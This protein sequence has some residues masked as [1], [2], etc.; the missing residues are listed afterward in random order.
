MD[1]RPTASGLPGSANVT[2]ARFRAVGERGVIRARSPDRLTKYAAVLR[3]VR[4]GSATRP[5]AT[6]NGV[7]RPP[8]WRASAPEPTGGHV[9]RWAA[10]PFG[11]AGVMGCG[12]GSWPVFYMPGRDT[13]AAITIAAMAATTSRQPLQP[14]EGPRQPTRAYPCGRGPRWWRLRRLIW[15]LVSGAG[16]AGILG[17]ARRSW[18]PAAPSGRRV[19]A[20]Y[21]VPARGS[22]GGEPVARVF[23]EHAIVRLPVGADL[24]LGLADL[25]VVDVLHGQPGSDLVM[26]MDMTHLGKG[27]FR[28]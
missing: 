22:G 6:S 5:R 7:G 11:R 20:T 27:R 8:P 3:L 10:P 19:V 25:V 24:L 12:E 23:I 17:L 9:R 18:L 4:T 2:A 14:T 28:R 15:I 26:T 1:R 16:A 21:G 13:A